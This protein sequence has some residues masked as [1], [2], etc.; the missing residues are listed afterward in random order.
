MDFPAHGVHKFLAD[1]HAQ[2]GP[3]EGGV[4][5][6]VS[7]LREG[8]ENLFQKG[9]AHA[10]AGILAP[11]GGRHPRV[12]LPALAYRKRDSPSLRR[13]FG[14]V[15]DDV[16]QDLLGAHLIPFD[17]G[18][19]NILFHHKRDAPAFDIVPLHEPDIFNHVLYGKRNIDDVNLS[20]LQF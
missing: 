1:G 14:R 13:E 20:G 16:H 9:P 4:R 3:L 19:R 10:D 11:V 5:L 8:I 17:P 6:S 2:P 15:A 7:F 18:N 12:I